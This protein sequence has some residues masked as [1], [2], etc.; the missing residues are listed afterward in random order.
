MPT[1]SGIQAESEASRNRYQSMNQYD[2]TVR[3]GS[4]QII[5]P[6]DQQIATAITKVDNGKLTSTTE[7]NILEA[8]ADNEINA[9]DVLASTKPESEQNAATGLGIIEAPIERLTLSEDVPNFKSGADENGVVQPLGGKFNRVGAAP[10]QVWERGDGRMEVIS[11]RHRLDLAK[12]SG[13]Q[14]IPA[15][16]HREADGFTKD[17]AVMLDTKL[18]IQDEQGETIDYVDAIRNGIIQAEE[19]TNGSGVLGREKGR[20]AYTIA[21]SGD[22]SVIAALR[23]GKLT[24]EAAAKISDAAPNNEGLQLLALKKIEDGESQA[25]AINTIMAIQTM[26]A[27]QQDTTGDLFG[28]DDSAAKQAEEIARIAIE[29]QRQIQSDLSAIRGAAKKPDVARKYGINVKKPAQIKAKI[30]ELESQKQ[31]WSKWHLY[32]E[33]VEEI[34]AEINPSANDQQMTQEASNQPILSQYT[35]EDLKQREQVQID[36]QQQEAQ[37]IERDQA[38]AESDNFNLTGSDSYLDQAA[39]TGQTDMLGELAD[40]TQKPTIETAQ[41]TE[42][43]ADQKK[44]KNRFSSFDEFAEDAV[45]HGKEYIHTI[46]KPPSS[47][48]KHGMPDMPIRIT[49]STVRKGVV[50]KHRL[51]VSGV[52]QA[53]DNLENHL[54]VFK[55]DA[56]TDKAK[57]GALTVLTTATDVDGKPVTVSVHLDRKHGEIDVNLIRSIHGKR[58]AK[59]QL[60]KWIAEGK[61]L[62]VDY[63]KL[64]D[65]HGI[66][67]VNPQGNANTSTGYYSKYTGDVKFAKS[68]KPFSSEK[69]ARMSATFK[70][71]PNAEIVPVE[72]GFGVREG[73]GQSSHI[74]EEQKKLKPDN[75]DS[76]VTNTAKELMPDQEATRPGERVK[77]KETEDGDTALFSRKKD[78]GTIDAQSQEQSN[79]PDIRTLEQTIDRYRGGENRYQKSDIGLPDNTRSALESLFGRRIVGIQTA[80]GFD[81]NGVVIGQN[82]G[83]I[84]VNAKADKPVINVIGHEFL[85]A[86]RRDN[87]ALYDQALDAM[88]N[89]IYQKDFDQFI[90]GFNAKTDANGEARQSES[91]IA[92]EL[93]AD[94][95]GDNFSQHG[96]WAKVS[97][98]MDGKKPGAFNQLMQAIKAFLKKVQSA[99]S[100]LGS[101]KYL[102]DVE[103]AQDVVAEM[104]ALHMKSRLGNQKAWS[105]INDKS[106]RYSIKNLGFDIPLVS[107]VNGSE[108]TGDNLQESAKRYFKENLAGKSIVRKELSS[109][110]QMTMKTGFK[111]MKN[112]MNHFGGK[113]KMLAAVKDIL[114]SGVHIGPVKPSKSETRFTEFHYFVGDVDF[115]GGVYTVR[116]D[117]GKDN[118]GKYAYHFSLENESWSVLGY[119]KRSNSSAPNNSIE[120]PDSDVKMSRQLKADDNKD[121]QNPMFS[122]K[123]EDTETGKIANDFQSSA[124]ESLIDRFNEMTLGAKSKALALLTNNQIAEVFEKVFFRFPVNPLVAFDRE[125]QEYEGTISREAGLAEQVKRKWDGLKHDESVDLQEIMSESTFYRIDP[126][127]DFDIEVER[128]GLEK[129][130]R[131]MGRKIGAKEGQ[132]KGRS[133]DSKVQLMAEIAQLK[134]EYADAKSEIEQLPLQKTQHSILKNALKRMT[135]EAQEVF[136]EVRDAYKAQFDKQV[137]EL[138]SRID[139]NIADE[140]KRKEMVGQVR[141]RFKELS[142]KGAYFPL[143]RFGDHFVIAKKGESDYMRLHF[144]TEG[145]AVRAA[146]KMR[147]DGW[148]VQRT[149]KTKTSES[150]V[151]DL[152]AFAN[153]LVGVVDSKNGALRT[154][155][156]IRDDIYQLMLQRMPEVSILKRSIHRKYV[157][158]FSKDQKRA[159]AQ[160]MFHGAYR[161]A[162]IRHGDVMKSHLEQIKEGLTNPDMI[163]EED[164]AKAAAVYNEMVLR[165]DDSMNAKG[166]QVAASLTQFG[167]A[168][169]LGGSL[170]AGLVNLAQ[171]PLF[172]APYLG[173]K[174]GFADATT[175]LLKAL[176]NYGMSGDKKLNLYDSAVSLE[177]NKKLKPDELD[178]IKKLVDDGTIENTQAHSLAQLSET[179]TIKQ[180]SALWEKTNRTIGWVYHNAEVM[181]REITALAAYRLAK[182]AGQ[183]NQEAFETAR[184]AIYDTHFNYS[185][186]NRARIMR[187]DTAKVLLLFKNYAQQAS[188][189]IV[190]NGVKALTGD[191]EAQKFVL[192]A[193]MSHLVIAGSAGLPV[194]GLVGMIASLGRMIASLGLD[195]DEEFDNEFRGWMSDIAEAAGAEDGRKVSE[196][197]T[198]GVFNSY[199]G[200]DISSRTSSDLVEMWVRADDIGDR[201]PMHDL[202]VALT[203]PMGSLVFKSYDSATSN[204]ANGDWWKGI[205][206]FIPVKGARDVGKALEM[207]YNGVYTRSGDYIMPV[208]DVKISDTVAKALGLTPSEISRRY[209]GNRSV[210]KIESRI[211]NQA[212]KLK[213]QLHKAYTRGEDLNEILHQIKLFNANYPRFAIDPRRSLSSR[214]RGNKKANETGL[215]VTKRNYGIVNESKMYSDRQ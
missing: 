83:V 172:T 72:G 112:G 150:D 73:S 56:G 187:S 214:L 11:G 122:R 128:A 139:R 27:V 170:G 141:E 61:G 174:F 30:Q 199:M 60:E 107:K 184:K 185:Y 74:K 147:D 89:V 180:Q 5:S 201:S 118:N 208:D 182:G 155:E 25:K 143:A 140:G 200:V 8:L 127:K 145:E 77:T 45:S 149:T 41:E 142:P 205:N 42:K 69:V 136:V 166:G 10:I 9:D 158:G 191:R 59:Q 210:K 101:S 57:Q 15:Q 51:T 35:P 58:D 92:E 99:L 23:A 163:S 156:S 28:F 178:M 164:N 148:D 86:L 39:V 106:I 67:L 87:P 194:W 204:M 96:F 132:I 2:I 161:I 85:H 53:I 133:G 52:K 181:N 123:F 157:A 125:T 46:G 36:A 183:A 152:T 116:V 195:D 213:S 167:F 81:F 1:D 193:T 153:D 98:H 135:P 75:T 55:T 24:D 65:I 124:K 43:K 192:G 49:S 111:K 176:A 175:E 95:L 179:N 203:G 162:K 97:Q 212:S 50:G 82:E 40:A 190:K 47:L 138:I 197:V 146:K 16:I 103:A 159:F 13:E 6:T 78:S 120:N 20:R 14:T 80:R 68:G 173:A 76:A 64:E 207:E 88:S 188:Y 215:R 91:V 186:H 121:S 134:R 4:G 177:R 18:N 171:T 211:N 110:I 12:R 151:N 206:T 115:E 63:E 7:K 154:G 32:P 168:Y 94:I 198:K 189:L 79:D 126:T 165:Y 31:A 84:Y 71:T 196:L 37:A 90:K 29:K 209:E 93:M 21:N 100:P 130:V 129:K 102:A 131:S 19:A 70:E 117:V 33:L 54:A 137:N 104:A 44:I 113:A 66:T 144:E 119:T 108:I 202:A 17:Q 34:K 114:E 62:F 160:T 105:E 22:S 26:P 38:Q 3:D 48:I 109:P 169:Y